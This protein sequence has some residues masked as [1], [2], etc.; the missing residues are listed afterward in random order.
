[1]AP[2]VMQGRDITEK[3]DVYAFGIVLW[4]LFTG[5]E[6]FAEYRSINSFLEAICRF[7]ERPQV[8]SS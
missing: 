4:E 1:M 5:L 6:P 7:N 8:Y 2:E 3:C